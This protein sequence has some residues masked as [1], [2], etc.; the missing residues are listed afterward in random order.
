MRLLQKFKVFHNHLIGLK[1]LYMSSRL[2]V[3]FER[4]LLSEASRGRSKR[5]FHLSQNHHH[6][7]FPFVK[8]TPFSFPKTVPQKDFPFFQYRLVHF[9]VNFTIFTAENFLF[10]YFHDSF[11]HEDS[12]CCWTPWRCACSWRIHGSVLSST[13][14]WPFP[15]FSVSPFWVRRSTLKCGKLE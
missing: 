11:T 5:Y 6:P 2:I 12:D 8:S 4:L 1:F 9:R 13:S 14:D 10:R 3:A 7:S 15:P